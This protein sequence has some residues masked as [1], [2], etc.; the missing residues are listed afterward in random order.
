ML[1]RSLARAAVAAVSL[2][3]AATAMP[4]DAFSSG[5]A[6]ASQRVA[7]QT[8]ARA[9]G[10]AA[11]RWQSSQLTAGR[12][13]NGQF[14]FDD[15]GLTIDTAFMLAADGHHRKRL[16]RVT[17]AI[18]HNYYAHYA[19]GSGSTSAGAMA[20]TLLATKVLN[21]NARHFGG[22]DVRARL[23]RLVA[24]RAAGFEAGRARDTGATDYSNTFAQSYA[25]L[26]LSRS[27]GAPQKVVNYLRKQQ[28]RRGYFRLTET[29][30]HSCNQRHGKADTDATALAIQALVSARRHGSSV[31]GRVVRRAASWLQ[32]A[33]KRNGSFGGGVSTPGSNSNSTGVAA[34]ALALTH[35]AKAQRKAARFTATM[36]IT[37]KKAG[38]S[39][40]RRDIGSI[41]YTRAG[42][43]NALTNGIQ[44]GERDQFRRATPMAFFAF[45]HKSL[46]TLSA[47]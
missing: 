27:G 23:L 40:A 36:Q 8:S 14:D 12:I 17:R 43:R 13:H 19:T 7:H 16:H 4:S 37:R 24:G 21:Q 41:A 11:A 33:Q 26:G 22:R 32:S 28:C 10:E 1:H 45:V 3:F 35:H 38:N 6:P 46:V 47:R 15:W 30:H 39:R 20:K 9:H 29:P 44:A 18:E 5:E 31:P 2:A 42:L 25:V 34:Q